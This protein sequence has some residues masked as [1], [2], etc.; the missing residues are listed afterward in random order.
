MGKKNLLW[1]ILAVS[2][3][4]VAV[5]QFV[6]A[7][8]LVIPAALPVGQR[9]DHRLL[10]FEGIANFRDLGGYPTGDGRQVKWGVLYRSGTLAHGTDADL[11]GLE[12]LR[13]TTLID[14]R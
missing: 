14:F 2:L 4:A 8:A 1:S 10:N 9:D 11:E 6:P 3:L 5:V 7:P 13:L 12:R